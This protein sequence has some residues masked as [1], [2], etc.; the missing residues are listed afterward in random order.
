MQ[1]AFGYPGGK[2]RAVKHIMK[3]L[4]L[5]LSKYLQ[6]VEPFCGGASFSL[7]CN[8]EK[9][10]LNDIDPDLYCLWRSI[11]SYIDDL[12][13]AVMDARIK[14]EDFYTLRDKL[15]EGGGRPTSREGVV[16]RGLEK[17]IIHKISY[18]NMGEMSGSPVGG[19]NQ[20]GKWKFD[21]RWNPTSICKSLRRAHNRLCDALLTCVDY[22]AVLGGCGSGN[23]MFVDP[24]YVDAGAK[25]YKHS[26]DMADH[27][28]LARALRRAEYKWI[29]TYDYHPRILELYSWARIYDLEFKYFIS[30]AYRSGEDMKIGKELLI[31]GD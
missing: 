2:S 20:T 8:I 29:L 22:E 16:Q 24:P 28:L 9:V 31:T 27:I 1:P 6:V 4:D 17:L 25:C 13:A 14:A 15:L 3:V 18:S 23:L 5:D 26:F 11:I 30:S 19:R 12:E 7:S 21:C 10:W